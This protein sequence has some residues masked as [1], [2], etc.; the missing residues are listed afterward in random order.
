MEGKIKEFEKRLNE[1]IK[2]L[3]IYKLN[4]LDDIFKDPDLTNIFLK[5]NQLMML[6]FDYITTT[7]NKEF[8]ELVDYL[9]ENNDK[10]NEAFNI[11]QFNNGNFTKLDL[12][13][14]KSSNNKELNKI[15]NTVLLFNLKK[16]NDNNFNKL[17]DE[18]KDVDIINYKFN[19]LFNGILLNNI[20][21]NYNFNFMN[22]YIKLNDNP[23]KYPIINN[24]IKL[25]FEYLNLMDNYIL[26]YNDDSKVFKMWFYILLS[27]VYDK[28]NLKFNELLNI[29]QNFNI[30][31]YNKLISQNNEQSNLITYIYFKKEDNNYKPNLRY[32]IDIKGD[33]TNEKIKYLKECHIIKNN[34]K[35][36]EFNTQIKENETGIYF[37]T[38]NYQPN[39]ILNKCQEYM[40]QKEY[41]KLIY[42]IF[43][44]QFLSRSTCL[45]GYFIYFYTT[46]K[47][48][49]NTYYHDII[50][51]TRSFDEFNDIINNENIKVD[52]FEKI[53]KIS[54]NNIIDLIN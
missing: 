44:S 2:G 25:T 23:A 36:I 26:K 32:T 46:H 43:N 50:A 14:I 45:F 5:N 35:F 41:N 48:L 51:L 15:L 21:E 30:L 42:F 17:F 49:K 54:L 6:L 39:E 47:I 38:S 7:K 29:F 3:E 52:N 34:D 18:I 31:F 12:N 27:Y 33:D 28:P 20:R 16:T 19:N 9:K 22:K 8:Y 24:N 37:D 13:Y 4:I 40:D 10:L 1:I 53:N 11:F